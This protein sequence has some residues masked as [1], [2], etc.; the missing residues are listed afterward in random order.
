MSTFST[1]PPWDF[2]PGY[3]ATATP[4]T[5]TLMGA[6][7]AFVSGLTGTFIACNVAGFNAVAPI[8]SHRRSIGI[9]SSSRPRPTTPR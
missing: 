7:F 2:S 3:S 9:C 4:I 1:G 8:A 6:I 5:N